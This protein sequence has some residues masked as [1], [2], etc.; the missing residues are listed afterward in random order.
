VCRR[1]RIYYSDVAG[2]R[3]VGT[4]LYRIARYEKE[5]ARPP[6]TAIVVHKQDGR[7]GEGFRMAMEQI[8][9]ANRGEADD[10][11]WERAVAEVFAYWRP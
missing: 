1:P 2:R 9:Y 7:P 8:G 10:A 11:M 6:L 5:H 3:K 4:D